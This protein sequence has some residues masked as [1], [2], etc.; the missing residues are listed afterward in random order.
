MKFT[1]IVSG[2][3]SKTDFQSRFQELVSDGRSQDPFRNPIS[4]SVSRTGFKNVIFD[5]PVSTLKYWD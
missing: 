1:A 5:C 2:T 4:R 3:V